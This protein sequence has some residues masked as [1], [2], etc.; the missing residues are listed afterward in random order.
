[1][2]RVSKVFFPPNADDAIDPRAAPPT[3][4]MDPAALLLTTER[5]ES[6]TFDQSPETTQ[7]T[8]PQSHEHHVPRGRFPNRTISRVWN[9]KQQQTPTIHDFFWGEEL[10]VLHDHTRTMVARM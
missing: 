9:R 7:V 6:H 5:F 8:L 2:E 4:W 3:R 10:Y 1:M